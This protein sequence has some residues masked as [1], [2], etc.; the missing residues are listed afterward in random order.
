MSESLLGLQ[1]A[2]SIPQEV[3]TGILIGQYKQYG[4]VIR[5]ADG[6]DKAGQIVRHLLPVATESL[7][8]PLFAPMSSVLGAVN[9]YQINRLSGQVSSLTESVHHLFQIANDTMVMSGLNLA[10]CAVGFGI[11]HKKL[12]RLENQLGKL[13]RSVQ[14]IRILMELEERAKLASALRD[15]LNISAVKKSS[16]RHSLLLNAKNI[17]GIVNFKYKELLTQA[18]TLSTAMVYCVVF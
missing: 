18:N 2:R 6:T 8:L 4:G 10:V 1:V 15:L 5:W 14:E 13:Q 12:T 16:H 3:I 11:L 17:F 9:T 7:N